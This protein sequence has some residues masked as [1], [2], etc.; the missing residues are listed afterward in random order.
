MGGG[1]DGV[2]PTKSHP[3]RKPKNC[4]WIWLHQ[5][6]SDEKH[7]VLL[8]CLFKSG[9]TWPF[10]VLYLWT[11]P[12]AD[13][14]YLPIVQSEAL[15][16]RHAHDS[17]RQPVHRAPK[18]SGSSMFRSRQISCFS[19]AP[20]IR[21]TWPSA[22]VGGGG[23]CEVR[24]LRWGEALAGSW[25]VGG[26]VH[27]HQQRQ[28]HARAQDFCRTPHSFSSFQCFC[29]TMCWQNLRKQENNFFARDEDMFDRLSS[30]KAASPKFRTHE[31]HRQIL[32]VECFG[33]TNK[34]GKQICKEQQQN[35]NNRS[36]TTTTNINNKTTQIIASSMQHPC[37]GVSWGPLF[38]AWMAGRDTL[39]MWLAFQCENW[40]P[41]PLAHNT[42]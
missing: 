11:T 9:T 33:P 8:L 20:V 19:S 13:M 42:L 32:R 1:G 30:R 18:T 39:P 14:S 2:A 7:Q 29:L 12:L 4:G 26:G 23:G 34:T 36:S 16:R 27:N 38:E 3:S 10:A 25:E 21:G 22:H 28:W 37:C 40:K 6:K 35:N 15:P 17:I 31:N 41:K 5:N 24:G